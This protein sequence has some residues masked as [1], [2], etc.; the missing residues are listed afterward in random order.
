MRERK[1]AQAGDP[2]GSPPES[3]PPRKSAV[4]CHRPRVSLGTSQRNPQTSRLEKRIE[5]FMAT[6]AR[7]SEGGRLPRTQSVS[8]RTGWVVSR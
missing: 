5:T 6:G 4:R 8:V 3:R 1:A 2:G 7:E